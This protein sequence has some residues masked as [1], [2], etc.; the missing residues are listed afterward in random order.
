MK[1]IKFIRR[2]I[3][4]LSFSLLLGSCEKFL[5]E[6][7]KDLVATS[8][9]YQTEE[10]AISAVNGVYSWLGAYNLG[11]GGNTAGIYHST[12]WLIQGLVSDELYSQRLG[13]PDLEALGVLAHNSE[14]ASVLEVW[15]MHYKVINFANIAIERVPLINMNTTLRTRLVN[16]AKFIRGLLYFNLVRMFGS[17]PLVLTED[18][19]MQPPRAS[20]D[21]IY[22]QIVTDLTDAEALPPNYL[23]G[24]GKGRATSGAAKAALA[25]VY[26]TMGDHPK[27]ASKAWEVIETNQYGL[28]DDFEDVWKYENRNGK[29]TVFAVSF[30]DGGGTISFWEVAAFNVHLLPTELMNNIPEI[31]NTQGWYHTTQ[32]LYDAYDP[33]DERRD[34]TLMTEFTKPDNSVVTLDKIYVQKYWDKEANPTTSPSESD[35]PVIRYSDVLLTYAEARANIDA[36][37]T[38]ANLYLNKTRN[39]ANLGDINPT[40]KPAFFEALLDERQREFAVEGHRW[41]DLVRLGKLAEKV[42][43]AKNITIGPDRNLFAIPLRETDLNPNLLP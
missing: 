20:V 35:Y 39:R 40:T 7:P 12:F 10:D 24:N 36:D 43:E 11:Y 30:G 6:S 34:V 1:N 32:A 16:E 15:R 41:F 4:L 33:S 37:L 14:T 21:D 17:V 22:A 42:Q 3:C 13:F 29:E 9:F 31:S 26:L 27:A 8:N 19:P 2:T 25:K 28:F 38:E 18:G 23:V 5:E